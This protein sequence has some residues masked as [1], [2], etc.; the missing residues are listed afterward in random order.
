MDILSEIIY[1][2]T[3]QTNNPTSNLNW[4]GRVYDCTYTVKEN[5]NI[6]TFLRNVNYHR[7]VNLSLLNRNCTFLKSFFTSVSVWGKDASSD[8]F[9]PVYL[10]KDASY[11][12]FY[13][14]VWGE[15]CIIWHFLPVCVRG[16]MHHMAFYTSVWGKECLNWHFLPV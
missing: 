16:R 2:P 1:H 12:I 5:W 11:G 3:F 15:G 6:N 7:N 13:Q 9:L 8:I 14:C 10:G 4:K